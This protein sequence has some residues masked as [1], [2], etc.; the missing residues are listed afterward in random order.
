MTRT[1]SVVL[2]FRF[3][4]PPPIFTFP[5]VPK[6][7]GV[8]LG[9]SAIE[10]Q[11]FLESKAIYAAP[12]DDE[13]LNLF[14][15]IEDL[16][17]EKLFDKEKKD[18]ESIYEALAPMLERFPA[19]VSHVLIPTPDNILNV[20]KQNHTSYACGVFLNS[21]DELNET[22]PYNAGKAAEEYFSEKDALADD[23]EKPQFSGS[24]VYRNKKS[25]A[26]FYKAAIDSVKRL[27]GEPALVLD[28]L[29][30]KERNAIVEYL[31]RGYDDKL[32]EPPKQHDGPSDDSD[33]SDSDSENH[34]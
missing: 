20:V 26:V 22:L 14:V 24:E 17:D 34:F 5:R 11:R 18:S 2:K 4:D 30:D 33:D 28:K 12:R 23:F 10:L 16:V 3:I 13:H 7:L 6:E 31:D 21:C 8:K 15:R 19:I 1:N 29:E 25:T 27:C 32:P 9:K